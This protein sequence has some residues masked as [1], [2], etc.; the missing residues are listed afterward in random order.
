MAEQFPSR[1]RVGGVAGPAAL[2]V[3]LFG[4]T[5]PLIITALQG[6]GIAL[7][8]ITVYTVVAAIISGVVYWRM[9][10]TAH[11]PLA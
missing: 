1:I 6:R 10:E 9:A 4:G 11:G 7:A 2:G 5:A 8:G 3:A